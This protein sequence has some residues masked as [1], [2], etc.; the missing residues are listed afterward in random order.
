MFAAYFKKAARSKV[1]RIMRGYRKL[2]N[3]N[4]PLV[5][6]RLQEELTVLN[7]GI[8]PSHIS[9]YIY[10]EEANNIELSARQ[11]MLQRHAGSRLSKAILLAFGSNQS[12][13]YSPVPV[14]WIN[15]IQEQGIPV[16]KAHSICRI[17]ACRSTG[18]TG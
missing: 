8:N 18:S 11:F 16:S 2:K 15:K 5:V 7:L 13:V 3:S 6:N 17:E 4:D 10:G 12:K 9:K 1:R 14:I